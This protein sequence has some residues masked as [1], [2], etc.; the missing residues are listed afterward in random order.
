[1]SHS[2]A[3]FVAAAFLA[4]VT[5][6][7]GAEN[8][9]P[10]AESLNAPAGPRQLAMG[11]ASVGQSGVEGAWN[12]PASLVATNSKWQFSLAGGPLFT[13]VEDFGSTFLLGGATWRVTDRLAV[14]LLGHMTNVSFDSYAAD[15]NKNGSTEQGIYCGGLSA[16]YRIADWLS[17]G[18][19][20]KGLG[21]RF[22]C[23]R[24]GNNSSVGSFVGDLG[25]ALSYNG[26]TFG[27]AMRNLGPDMREWSYPVQNGSSD[28]IEN[29]PKELRMGLSWFNREPALRISAEL[30][31]EPGSDG[32]PAI[33]GG[34]EWW[35]APAFALRLGLAV[36]GGSPTFTGGLTGTINKNFS[37]DYGIMAHP[38]G[39][40]HR[41]GLSL[42]LGGPVAEEAAP[43][44]AAPAP[45]PVREEKPAAAVPARPAGS[46][47]NFA[48]ADLAA[49][50]VSA[51]DSAVIAD[52]LRGELVKT[53]AFTIIEKQNMDKVLSEQGFQQTGCTSE[54]CAVKIGKLLNVQRMAV[55]S[56]GKLMDSY[57]LSI[58]VVNV[59]TGAIGYA[60]SVE[61]Q[62][63]SDLRTGVK[64]LAARM[65]RQ[66]R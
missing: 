22:T 12:N 35:P 45:A 13:G 23:E 46:K 26:F 31:G 63:V 42:A 33:G 54:E 36:D 34:A 1:M 14:G 19:T 41:V 43:A 64:D 27:L 21:E 6:V 24:V 16:A 51:S 56:F 11:G 50:G 48:I 37:V 3:R 25:A 57:I 2:A 49:Q 38:I 40:I 62:K 7:A 61:G 18:I 60:D 66:I 20:A 8:K 44:E 32:D 59:E 52:L 39:L 10:G 9:V 55:G 58:R 5:S 17:A 4:G 29:A 53:G 28:F 15:G 47:L 30:A 65:A